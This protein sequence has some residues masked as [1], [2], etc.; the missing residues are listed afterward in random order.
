MKKTITTPLLTLVAITIGLA[1][2]TAIP[3]S[4]FEQALIDQSIDSDG[5]VNGVILT[6]DANG[7]SGTLNVNN[8]GITDLTG[9]EA[10]TSIDILEVRDNALTSLDITGL[11][12][13][14]RLEAGGNSLTTINTT[15]L[16]NLERLIVPDNALTSIDLTGLTN[17][18]FLYAFN[19]DIS[20]LDLTDVSLLQRLYVFD[21]VNLGNYN[22]DNLS[23]LDR[24]R[25][26]NTGI[27][28]LDL[29]Q[30]VALQQVRIYDNPNLETVNIQNGANTD[31]GTGDFEA[32][33]NPSLNCVQV[34]DV[35]YSTSTW[36]TIDNSNVFSTNCVLNIGEFNDFQVNIFPNPTIDYLY[37]KTDTQ[38][39]Y[40]IYSL[41]GQKVM[42]NSLDKNESIIDVSELPTGLHIII[43][44]DTLGKRKTLRFSKK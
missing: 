3:D 26:W 12:G 16:A 44:E 6:A 15:G 5:S 36:T 24:L 39:Q 42:S 35:T 1:Q 22:T 43:L 37:V 8:N 40:A 9:I 23:I 41:L 7:Y 17:L 14:L 18:R 29:S 11:G 32:N 2:T 4:N 31:L 38:L 33:N 10:F 34:D 28:S 30:N 13:L 19:N 25:S 27:T 20:T 21:N